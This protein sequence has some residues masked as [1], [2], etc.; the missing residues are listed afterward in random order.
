MF[1]LL[2]IPS[3]LFK[4]ADFYTTTSGSFIAS[5]RIAIISSVYEAALH[6]D[7]DVGVL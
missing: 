7:Q 1:L 5:D 3:A 6:L 4:V 2:L